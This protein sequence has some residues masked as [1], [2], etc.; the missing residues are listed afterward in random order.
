VATI[1]TAHAN[2]DCH[3]TI[4]VSALSFDVANVPPVEGSAL[5]LDAARP[6][7]FRAMTALGFNLPQAGRVRLTIVDVSG[8]TVAELLNGD[9]AAGPGHAI[10]Q[11]LTAE[12]RQVAPGLYFAR[13][14]HQGLVRSIRIV[15]LR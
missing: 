10:W 14:E 2:Y 3:S 5:R 11:G 8:R 7:P 15:R 12:A 4:R 1:H 6:N 9:H 13:L